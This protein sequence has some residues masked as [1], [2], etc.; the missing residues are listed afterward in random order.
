M[1]KLLDLASNIYYS[2]VQEPSDTTVTKI[3]TWLLAHIGDLN[4]RLSV[5]HKITG[6]DVSPELNEGEAIIF[7][8]LYLYNYYIQQLKL[9]LGAAQFSVISVQEGD[10][11][12][13]QV[14]RNEIAKVWRGLAQDTLNNLNQLCKQYKQNHALPVSINNPYLTFYQSFLYR[15]QIDGGPNDWGNPNCN[16][17]GC[18]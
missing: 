4:T 10:S 8:V 7:G 11:K 9:N 15:K 17:P 16:P 5:C 12:V 13:V 18:P 2:D 1:I 6:N 3:L 14:N